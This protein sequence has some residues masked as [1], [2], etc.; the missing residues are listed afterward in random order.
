MIG[1]SIFT[2]MVVWVLPQMTLIYEERLSLKEKNFGIQL[3][4]NL[5]QEWVA[6][7]EEP[8]RTLEKGKYGTEFEVS[9]TNSTTGIEIC[10]DWKGKNNRNEKIC[11]H[12]K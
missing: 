8:S 9:W 6:T 1:L 10:I 3:C 2:F 5:L 11:G 4:H 7:K 12:A